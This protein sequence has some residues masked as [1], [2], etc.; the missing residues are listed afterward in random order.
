V[1]EIA[2]PLAS[3]LHLPL[4][5]GATIACL[6]QPGSSGNTQQA[7]LAAVFLRRSFTRSL[8]FGLALWRPR[9][10]VRLSRGLNQ[11]CARWVVHLEAED[12]R[13]R[14]L[15]APV[16]R[17]MPSAGAAAQE[18][19]REKGREAWQQRGVTVSTSVRHSGS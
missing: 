13:D 11:S 2:Q 10:R 15:N 18:E 1:P 16:D 5:T 19:H 12:A 17:I 14:H 7:P 6:S 3:P 9:L 4:K 8:F